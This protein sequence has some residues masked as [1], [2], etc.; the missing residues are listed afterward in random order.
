MRIESIETLLPESNILYGTQEYWDSRYAKDKGAFE[1]FGFSTVMKEKLKSFLKDKNSS[2]LH[3]GCGNSELGPIMYQEGY[4]NITNI[5]YSPIVIDDMMIKFA[6]TMPKMEWVIGNVFDLDSCL[7]DKRLYDFAIDKGTLDAFLTVKHD[8][9]NPTEALIKHIDSYMEQ[10]ANHLESGG[11]FIHVTFAQPHFRN[12][13]LQ[14]SFFK[15]VKV[16]NLND[17]ETGGGFDYFLY[18]CTKL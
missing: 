2:I 9:W 12:R 10:V 15:S 5:D 1:W 8:P 14:Q 18:V 3:L 13:F 7:G 16:F 17:N 4:W 6:K 11:Q